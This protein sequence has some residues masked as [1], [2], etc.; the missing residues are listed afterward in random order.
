MKLASEEKGLKINIE[1]TECMVVTN[2][3]ENP[4]CSIRIEQELVKQV[5]EFKYLGSTLTTDARCDTEIKRRIGIAKTAFRKMNNL[6]TN[7]RIS[8][9][10]RKRAVKT[11]V[12]STLLYGSETWTVSREMERRLDA[13]EMWC[14]RRMLRVSW[15]AR[16]TNVDI[17][18][19][20]GSRRELVAVLRR[21]QMAFLGHIMRANGLENL[22]ITGRI[23]GNRGRGRPRKKYLD[24]M[25]EVIGGVT[26]QELLGMTRDRD[27]WRS[28]T[29][30][31]FNGLPYR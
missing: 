4:D 20:I 27:R 21:R 16:R 23:S 9:E 3:S 17:L 2:L 29:G 24:R 11:Y 14:W 7:S 6:L 10:T 30:N 19:T 31:V 26:T 5:D 15:T 22:A 25:K 28:I 1:K 8:I 12:W 13:V 18:E